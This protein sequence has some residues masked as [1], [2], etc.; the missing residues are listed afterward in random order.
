MKGYT[1]ISHQY[2]SDH[3]LSVAPWYNIQKFRKQKKP[4]INDIINIEVSYH[5]GYMAVNYLTQ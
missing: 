2:I 1:K 5:H 4:F 3:L